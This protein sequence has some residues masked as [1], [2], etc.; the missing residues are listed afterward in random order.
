MIDWADGIETRNYGIKFVTDSRLLSEWLRATLSFA[1]VAGAFLF[2]SWSRG[3][4]VAT[5]YENQKLFALEE[6]LQQIEKSLILEEESLSSPERIDTIAR[7]ELGMVPL[8]PK[9][10]I[11]PQR[12]DVESSSSNIMAIADSKTSDYKKPAASN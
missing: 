11:L 5:G 6:S 7:N 12:R 9:Q 4:I 3:Q 10:L 8:N 2:Y 1:M